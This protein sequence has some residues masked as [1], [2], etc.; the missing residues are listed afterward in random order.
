MGGALFIGEGQ[1]PRPERQLDPTGSVVE[2]FAAELRR[3]RD[4]AGRPGYR[5]LAEQAHFSTTTLSEAAGGRRMPS[6]A[7]TLAFVE[8]CGGDRREWVGRWQAARAELLGPAPDGS[9]Q[10]NGNRPPYRG[11]APYEAADAEWFFGR[12]ELL[13]E[14]LRL[15]AGRRFLAVFG[16]SG[17]GKSSLLR[18]GLLPA[19]EQ[20][21]LRPGSEVVTLLVTPGA[22]PLEE[23]AV[24]LAPMANVAAG[25]LLADLRAG[26]DRLHLAIRQ[27]LASRVPDAELLLVVD[28]FEDVFRLCPDESERASTVAALVAAARA[29]DSRVRVVLGVR[30][31]FYAHIGGYPDLVAALREAHLL[32]TPMSP[33][34]LRAAVTQPA[35]HAGLTVEGDLVSVIVAEATG[36][37]GALPLVS[38]ALLE[39]WRR[40]RGMTLTLAGYTESGGVDGA[41]AQTAERVYADLDPAGQRTMHRAL[42]RL[43][44]VGE[45]GEAGRRRVD[46]AEFDLADPRTVA[47]LRRL[48]DA[49]LLTFGDATVEIA[50]EALLRAWPRLSDW[51][52]EDREYLRLHRQLTEA[53]AI[54]QAHDR[55]AG[56]LY[57][58]TRLASA[59]EWA[60]RHGAR[61]TPKEREFL[62][63]ST[64][65]GARE[66]SA[67]RRRIRVAIGALAAAVLIDSTLAGWALHESSQ[68]RTERNIAFSRQVAAEARQQLDVDPELAV[69][70][71]D[72]AYA[73]RPTQEADAVLRQ[74]V[75]ASRIRGV[76]AEP[77][78]PV[79]A[80]SFTADGRR[81]LTAA[82]NGVVRL[83]P[84]DGA[85]TATVFRGHQGNVWGATLSPDGVHLATGGGDKTVRLWR[86]ADPGRS[87]ILGRHDATVRNVAFS[88]DGKRLASAS[89]DGTVKIWD[90]TGRDAPRVLRG[91]D[92]PVLA[93]AFSP[94]GQ[95]L[96]TGGND[97]TIRLWPRS[98]GPVTVLRGHT[99][100]VE[101]LAYSPD[102]HHL[103]SA[104]TD[105]TARVWPLPGGE[106]LVLRGHDGTVESVAF[107]PDGTWVATT[108]NDR[109]VRLWRAGSAVHPQILRGH[110]GTV[111]TTS[112]SPD[113]RRLA[114]ASDDGTVRI[115][116]PTLAGD[117]V[118]LTG[119]VG[120]VWNGAVSADGRYAASA[121]RDHTVRVWDLR[122]TRRPVVLTGHTGEVASVDLSRD[123]GKVVSG[124][125]DGTVR[126]WDRA[127]GAPVG[128]YSGHDGSVTQVAFGPDGRWVASG[129]AD[130]TVRVWP[131]GGHGAPVVLRGGA[132]PVRVWFSADG[133][134]LAGAGWDGT[135][136]L[137]DWTRGTPPL[138]LRGH[139]GPVWAAS[140]SPD[141]RRVVSAGSDGTVRVWPADGRGPAIVL[142][143]HQGVAWSAQF[144]ADGK[145]V[146]SAGSDATVRVWPAAGAAEPVVFSGFGA[147][148]ESV[149]VSVTGQLLTTHGDGLVQ[150]WRCPVCGPIGEVR[151]AVRTHVTRALTVA[152]RRLYLNERVI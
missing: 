139:E 12:A 29:E 144:S 14:I 102:G 30:A 19:A 17:I 121:G 2:Q 130:G 100:S 104:S 106:P 135:V 37:V 18:A 70:L 80:V 143:A 3:L 23:L 93:V 28:Q 73:A 123:G 1:M 109:T 146:V 92:G 76:L 81:L 45:D 10:G 65:A 90:L 36:R 53:T 38:H 127:S 33:P 31:D 62:A 78:G 97:R 16:A 126:V 49:R 85:G 101:Y 133:R 64:A 66:S 82:D 137:W 89:D 34:E 134:R 21:R 24:R 152:E 105:G 145:T 112:F 125:L 83:S 52:V 107:S 136:R 88:P 128:V 46:V 132:G 103:A 140:F 60:A 122:G 74:A 47:V 87:T 61:M 22:H 32:V 141:G 71:A 118:A 6:L 68:A 117:P 120:P 129:G 148:V 79:Y 147:S 51:I 27:A 86:V 50:H 113:G 42:L 151:A 7:V 55:D 94:D 58:G 57:R 44:D 124:S 75:L 43:V 115:W 59:R 108:G 114:S 131:A 138:V 11:L 63:A 95:V 110:R 5:E 119:H 77:D 48:A 35:A 99:A 8:V 69:L 91:H 111:W 149:A 116:D 150:V 56:A 98:G 4:G 84:V 25:T 20:G 39:A 96:A 54:W 13:D 15:L 72:R 142:G 67:R 41:I 9:R 26:P 40:R